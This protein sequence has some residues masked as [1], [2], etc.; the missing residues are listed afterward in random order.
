MQRSSTGRECRR[1]KADHNKST[2]DMISQVTEWRLAYEKLPENAV[3]FS[4]KHFAHAMAVDYIHHSNVGEMVGTQSWHETQDAIESFCD[5]GKKVLPTRCENLETVNTFEAVKLLHNTHEAMDN[6]GLLTVQEICDIHRVLLQ[7]LHPDCGRIHTREVY[8]HWQGGRHYYPPPG[9]AE[10][11]F[12]ALIDHHNKRMTECPYARNSDEYTAYIFN[13]A[14]RLLFEFVSVHPFGDGNGRTCRLLATYVLGL[15]TPF[16]VSLYHSPGGNA[17]EDYLNAIVHCREHPEEG[18]HELTAMLIQGAWRGWR[19][20]FDNLERRRELK[21]GVI[22][23][24]IVVQKSLCK[25]EYVTERVGR[26]WAG[27]LRRGVKTDMECVVKA[28]IR[29]VQETDIDRLTRTQYMQ[30]TVPIT[31]PNV[32]I[33]L[34][35]YG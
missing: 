8:T 11:M 4:T 35:I 13:C 23:G 15:I 28:I 31:E 1:G 9:Q 25:E 33:R 29:A 5:G 12:Y 26:I 34:D 22:I 30:K 32:S 14:A 10:E 7:G 2:A 3:K 20:L 6:T 21:P 16:P 17:R 24:P 27:A 18:P 19:C